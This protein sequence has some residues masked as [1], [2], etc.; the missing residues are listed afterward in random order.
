MAHSKRSTSKDH[1]TITDD[2]MFSTVFSDLALS[3]K[4]VET[5][6]D[7]ELESV[8]LVEDHDLLDASPL[9]RA[10]IV[11]L[12]VR[13][14]AGNTFDV[15]MQNDVRRRI[16]PR[17]A[18]YYGS[19]IDIAMLDPSQGFADLH[20]RVVIFVCPTDPFGRGWRRYNFPRICLQD[21]V[22]LDD[23]TDMVFVNAQGI[24]GDATDEFKAFLRYLGDDT[25]VDGDFVSQIDAAVRSYRESHIWRRK[26]MLW[27]QKNRD[28][29]S[30]ARM[31]G[32]AEGLEE[33]RA[34]GATAQLDA[35]SQLA[36]RLEAQGRG[37]EAL[38]A[39]RD[40]ALRKRLM[41]EFGIDEV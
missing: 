12:L 10:G 25:M 14:M 7:L 15:E 1:Y 2:F 32:R 21:G 26:R 38:R 29:L 20:D 8:E 34:E 33:G 4:L 5:L 31:E 3:K 13:D 19:L 35:L 39:L 17:R 30:D 36:E 28:D 37:N 11:D 40:P 23:G 6:L 18:R 9:A 41:R 24:R 16:L 27:S 22:P